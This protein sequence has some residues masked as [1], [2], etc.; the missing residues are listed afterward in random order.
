[1][2][3]RAVVHYHA[4]IRLDRPGD[5][6]Q[7]PEVEV[8]AEQ[9]ERAVR[10]AA[11][12]VRLNVP[13]IGQALTWGEQIDVQPIRHDGGLDGELTPEKVAAYLSK[14]IIKS[15]GDIFGLDGVVKDPKAAR[16]LGA[17]GH[18]VRMME[19]T[20]RLAARFD[21]LARWVHTLGFRGHIQSKSRMF[22]TTLRAIQQERIDYEQARR[23]QDDGDDTTLLVG[24]WTFDGI[25]HRN[26]G[27]RHL[28]AEG[29]KA[30][31]EV[32]MEW[33][34]GGMS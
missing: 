1:M 17:S 11:A 3:R 18:V 13:E 7:P 32:Y 29:W 14:Y 21:G 15:A 4:V 6:W 27:D 16:R 25:G 19:T 20:V 22:S 2:Q 8:T 24:E 30:F 23:R 28:A 10:A 26:E 12:K 34:T 5:G 33:R 9:M 31:R